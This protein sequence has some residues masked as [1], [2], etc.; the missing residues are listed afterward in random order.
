M[1]SEDAEMCFFHTQVPCFT[2]TVSS[3]NT[4]N[5]LREGTKMA[6][7]EKK[8][9]AGWNTETVLKTLK[10]SYLGHSRSLTNFTVSSNNTLKVFRRGT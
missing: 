4:L 6:K 2:H 5:V 8:P 3:N 7:E 10:V 1:K 9:T